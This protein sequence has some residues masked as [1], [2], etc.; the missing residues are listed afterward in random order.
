MTIHP[1]S[2]TASTLAMGKFTSEEIARRHS[3]RLSFFANQYTRTHIRCKRTY[4]DSAEVCRRTMTDSTLEI[5]A[6]YLFEEFA[7]LTLSW[8]RLLP[9]FSCAGFFKRSVRRNRIYHCKNRNKCVV[10]KYRRNQCR[11]C[12]YRSSS[13][14]HFLRFWIDSFV[15]F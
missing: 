3:H 6:R 4:G 10:D 13:F 1:A 15:S 8:T 5:S 7:L 11:A 14:F 2:T 9:S 12:R